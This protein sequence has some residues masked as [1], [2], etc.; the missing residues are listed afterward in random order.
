MSY[1]DSG[2]TVRQVNV[3][4]AANLTQDARSQQ[5]LA[6][7][8]GAEVINRNDIGDGLN[9]GGYGFNIRNN[10]IRMARLRK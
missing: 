8:P 9:T 10:R 6:A 5:L 4:T 7:V 1:R 3:L 2:G